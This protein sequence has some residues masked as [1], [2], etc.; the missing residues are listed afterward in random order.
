MYTF[1]AE[2]FIFY[3]KQKKINK[4]YKKLKVK[5]I[6]ICM[7]LIKKYIYAK[8]YIDMNCIPLMP[9]KCPGCDF[10]V[11]LWMYL[12]VDAI[13][14][15]LN[16]THDKSYRETSILF[17]CSECDYNLNLCME[18]SFYENIYFLNMTYARSYRGIFIP[19]QCSECD[20]YISWWMELSVISV[21]EKKMY[22]VN[23]A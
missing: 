12:S 14:H 6:Y 11:K 23:K 1:L 10:S 17:Q 5:N 22:T 8:C 20:Y 13:T 2:V 3:I 4:N 16:M 21:C 7:F 15:Y 18:L 19:F 9:F